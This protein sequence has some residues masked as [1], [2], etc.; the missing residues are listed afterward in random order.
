MA[1]DIIQKI[2]VSA[3]AT[4]DDVTAVDVPQ[5]GEIESI[6]CSHRG[7]GMD[8]LNDSYVIELSFA[9][10]NTFNNNDARIS[11][12]SWSAIQAFLTSG[13]GV[14]GKETFVGGINIPVFAGERL[15]VHVSLGGGTT[16]AN[17]EIYLYYRTR[18]GAPPRRSARRR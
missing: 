10:S 12:I 13:G 6:W 1:A 7:S 14:E 3:A 18:G 5:D 17:A 15:H 9:S 4:A 16:Q 2:V 11:I 8:A